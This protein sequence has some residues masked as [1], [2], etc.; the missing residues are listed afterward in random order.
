MQFITLTQGLSVANAQAIS[1][2]PQ[3]ADQIKAA[4]KIKVPT[5]IIGGTNDIFQRD[6]ALLYEQVKRNA[7]AK[8]VLLPGAHRQRGLAH[9]E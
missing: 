5:F 9:R 7:S 2:Y 4:K 6:E 3:Y 1:K 8:L